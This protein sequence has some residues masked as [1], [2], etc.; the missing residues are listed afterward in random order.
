MEHEIISRADARA[1]GLSREYYVKNPE[2]YL[3][4]R[5]QRASAQSVASIS[6]EN[7]LNELVFA[8][9][10]RLA[11]ARRKATGISWHV[12]HMIPLRAKSACGLHVWNNLQVIPATLNIK[13]RNRLIMT[14]PFEW[15]ASL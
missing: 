14:E 3:V 13:K 12:D 7:E 15:I 6:H 4:Y 11:K 8:E 2:K 5:A 10:A 1:Q 9:A